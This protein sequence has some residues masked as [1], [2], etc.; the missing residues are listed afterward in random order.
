MNLQRLTPWGIVAIAVGSLSM[1]L[2]AEH[3]FRLEPCIL[4]LYQRVPY[5]ATALLALLALK[6]PTRSP[7]I[8]L[9]IVLCGLIYLI[10]AG[11]AVYHVGVEQHWWL[12]GCTGAPAG[13][14]SFDQLRAGLAT[15]PTKS[16]DDVD[17]PLFGISMA[18]YNAAFSIVVGLASLW[19][20]RLIW[21]SNEPKKDSA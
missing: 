16:C 1:A 18:T 3:Y 6:I 2:I 8:P 20:A 19:A 14:L 5:V 7:A 13:Q 21:K 4:C 12:S 10:G 11:I 9:I 15:A 17:W